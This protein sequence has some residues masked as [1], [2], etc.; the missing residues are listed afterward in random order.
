M[1]QKFADRA[2]ALSRAMDFA[3]ESNQ[4][5]FVVNQNNR[6]YI[7]CDLEGLQTVLP[8]ANYQTIQPSKWR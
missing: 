5:H 2:V 6:G 3:D 8:G 1:K 4:E 7:V